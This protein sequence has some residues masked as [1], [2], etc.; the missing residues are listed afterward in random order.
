MISNVN[1]YYMISE[2]SPEGLTYTVSHYLSM[3]W[4]LYGNPTILIELHS[5][6][7]YKVYAQA[8]VMEFE[9]DE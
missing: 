7:T 3:G 6:V 5:M 2:E 4:S 1:K 8:V 9:E